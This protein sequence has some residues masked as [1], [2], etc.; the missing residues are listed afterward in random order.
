MLLICLEGL[1]RVT[2]GIIYIFICC[3]DPEK[4]A[5]KNQKIAPGVIPADLQPDFRK[6]NF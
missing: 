6:K 1:R 3:L 5:I 2:E 4:K